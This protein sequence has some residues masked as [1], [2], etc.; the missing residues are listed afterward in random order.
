MTTPGIWTLEE[1]RAGG[2]G[3]A[4]ASAI[5]AGSLAQTRPRLVGEERAEWI[6][7]AWA[8]VCGEGDPSVNCCCLF[9]RG[10]DWAAARALEEGG[11]SAW[12]LAWREIEEQRPIGRST[13]FGVRY[14]GQD[15]QHVPGLIAAM[16]PIDVALWK[17][18]H[19]MQGSLLRWAI[20]R[21][22]CVSDADLER[23]ISREFGS[24]NSGRVGDVY[25][26]AEGCRLFND[27]GGKH[28]QFWY[29]GAEVEESIGGP[30]LVRRARGLLALPEPGSL[31]LGARAEAPPARGAR[32]EPRRA[33]HAAPAV[34]AEQC[35]LL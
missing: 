2:P 25:Y 14:Y 19:G 33:R 31:A 21:Q 3:E 29:E 32:G 23:A 10:Y 5:Q 22:L 4:W 7:G 35:S 26:R 34:G 28:P 20:Y 18:L 9:R 12:H 24:V 13:R 6:D 11:W 1:I 15:H 16:Q 17:A 8:A 27:Q 30:A